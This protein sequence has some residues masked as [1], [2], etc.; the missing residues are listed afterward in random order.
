V[1]GRPD[2]KTLELSMI[3]VGNGRVET[4][5]HEEEEETGKEGYIFFFCRKRR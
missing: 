2:T 3:G 1:G 4:E 5:E